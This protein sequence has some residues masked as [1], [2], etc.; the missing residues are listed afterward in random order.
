MQDY[1][2]LAQE[3][4]GLFITFEGGEGCGKSLQSRMLFDW[5]A[6]F[7]DAVILTRE[8]GGTNLSENI[9]NW[10]LVGNINSWD[11][12]TEALLFLAARSDHWF[13]KILPAL[14]AGS[15]V[16]CD[17]FQD[18]SVV[19]QGM[20]K[21][22]PLDILDKIYLKITGGRY[23]D[24]TY[25]LDIPPE[26]GIKRSISRRNNNETRF[27]NMDIEFH[28]KVRSSFLKLARHHSG[29]YLILDGNL[30][31]DEI[32]KKIKEDLIQQFRNIF[33]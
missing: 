12:I 19:Y 26:V 18:S 29:R 24:R 5:I 28:K 30:S 23:P 25:L 17:R 8:P 32:H 33:S 16:I 20:C 13:K 7:K 11:P 27:E 6:S 1:T 9:R 3:H 22:V 2:S 4:H 31:P 21:G 14:K 10:L 15:F